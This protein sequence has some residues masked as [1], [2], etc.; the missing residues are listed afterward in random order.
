M[1]FILEMSFQGVLP[2]KISRA[3]INQAWQLDATMINTPHMPPHVVSVIAPLLAQ[4][5]LD[6]AGRACGR[7]RFGHPCTPLLQ[8]R[9]VDE[10]F[11]D[12]VDLA[13]LARAAFRRKG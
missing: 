3:S 10:I 5:A 6:S 8:R 12:L 7:A 11:V 13:S 4:L 1:V 9:P 2:S